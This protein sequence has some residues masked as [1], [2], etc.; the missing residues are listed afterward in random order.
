MGGK[1]NSSRLTKERLRL[2]MRVESNEIEAVSLHGPEPLQVERLVHRWRLGDVPKVVAS[3]DEEVLLAVQ[4]EMRS[5][6]LHRS[7][8]ESGVS[9]RARHDRIIAVALTQLDV[10]VVEPRVSWCP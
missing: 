6:N 2:K 9:V 4:D 8:P 7:Q 3:A 1:Q 5:V 10:G